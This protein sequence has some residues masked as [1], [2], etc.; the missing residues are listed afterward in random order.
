MEILQNGY[1]LELCDGAFPLSTDSMALAYFARLGKNAKVLDLGSGC[2][3]LGL[4][5]CAKDRSC[6]V[7]GVE[8]SRSAH[9]TA[10]ENIRR[11]GLEPRMASIC[12]DLKSIPHT[13][14]RGS[15]SV[16]ISNPPYFIGGGV[17]SGQE[18]AR[19]EL[20]C[21]A[22]D[23]FSA[24]AWALKY[25]GDFYL[26]HKPERLGELIKL[27]GKY[28]MEC[29]RL[30]M[31]RHSPDTLPGVV[32]LAFR[33]GGRPGLKLEEICL[34]DSSGAFSQTYREIYHLG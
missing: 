23:V 4:L 33:K 8:L 21:S 18:N 19:H 30:C 27:G 17:R 29:K 13:L 14:P 34:R 25:G 10:L 16:C 11:N 20:Q 12:A 6:H 9:E 7:T 5:L 15:F 3:T 24:S 32:L 2:G 28:A 1:T 22:E 26:V 31:L